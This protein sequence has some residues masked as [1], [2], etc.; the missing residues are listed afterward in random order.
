MLSDADAALPA[1]PH[2]HVVTVPG[3]GVASAAALLAQAVD[4]NRCDTPAR[5][6][7]FGGVFPE[8]NS[9]GVAKFGNPL[10]PGR[11]RMSRQ[12]NDLVRA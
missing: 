3:S 5:L 8:E 7:G 11:H 1:S 6:V 2:L 9:S 12:G 10:P 4:I